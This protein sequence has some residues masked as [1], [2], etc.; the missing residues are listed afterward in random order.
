MK[1]RDYVSEIPCRVNENLPEYQRKL[2][3]A[4]QLIMM[5]IQQKL[6][7]IM[8]TQNMGPLTTEPKGE[9]S[10]KRMME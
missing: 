7:N 10:S 1:I 8:G 3:Q 2:I 5:K 9:I 4:N 6:D